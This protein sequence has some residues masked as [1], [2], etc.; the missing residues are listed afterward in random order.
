MAGI[1]KGSG[2]AKSGHTNTY[3]GNEIKKTQI[4]Q[5]DIDRATDQKKKDP[6]VL[7]IAG[8]KDTCKSGIL[9]D[10]IS[11]LPDGKMGVILDFDHSM[12]E[13]RNTF[14]PGKDDKFYF[15]N[16][17]GFG[18]DLKKGLLVALA[19]LEQ[20]V[21]N[22]PDKVGLIACEGMDRVYKRSFKMTC[23]ARGYELED[24]KFFG[25]GG[26]KE[27]SPMDWCVRNDFNAD[28]IDQ[29]YSSAADCGCPLIL[30]THAEDAIN[31]NR[32]VTKPDVP[33]WYRTV[34]EY[35]SFEFIAKKRKEGMKT[36]R[37]VECTKDRNDKGLYDQRFD[38]QIFDRTTKD[39][40]FTGL[41]DQIKD[42]IDFGF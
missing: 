23:Q 1:V 42:V 9:C 8:K 29:L 20:V 39:S 36:I 17:T 12:K 27:F 33:I 28:P 18:K 32:E 14:H 31:Q 2:I 5:A 10:I 4:S 30:T 38:I 11:N 13:I 3:R 7:A 19:A 16:G 35:L 24:I 15:I 21:L 22:Q 40:T 37:Y 25:K 41:Y 26:T 34:P 6:L